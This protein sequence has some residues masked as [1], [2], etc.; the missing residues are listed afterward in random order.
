MALTKQFRCETFW[1]ERLTKHLLVRFWGQRLPQL[2]EKT[3]S[4]Q[5]NVFVHFE[6]KIKNI[7]ERK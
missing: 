2:G 5:S 1:A 6:K 4:I 7:K 3:V